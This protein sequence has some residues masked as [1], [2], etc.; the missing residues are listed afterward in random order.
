M[1]NFHKGVAALAAGVESP[2]MQ[3][4]L[5]IATENGIEMLGPIP[6]HVVD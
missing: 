5:A 3:A 1:E 6:E 2:D 4:V